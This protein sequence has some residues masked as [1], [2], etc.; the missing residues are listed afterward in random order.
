MSTRVDSHASIPATPALSEEPTSDAEF[1]FEI[2]V[3]PSCK[4]SLT[5]KM[6]EQRAEILVKIMM[7][8]GI[9]LSPPLLLWATNTTL[10]IEYAFM[11][12]GLQFVT[13]LLLGALN[14]RGSKGSKK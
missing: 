5:V 10:T 7:I 11:V 1:K 13:L 14:G 8:L 2:E 3:L 6:P 4:G 12:L 9:L